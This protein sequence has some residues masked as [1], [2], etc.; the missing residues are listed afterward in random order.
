MQN[1]LAK[2]QGVGNLAW[3]G[4]QYGTVSAGSGGG[5]GGGVRD[6]Q[7][8]LDKGSGG[9]SVWGAARS[10]VGC[11]QLDGGA[12]PSSDPE[13]PRSGAAWLH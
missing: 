6:K 10:A 5:G 3:F 2:E 12:L 7:T 4:E 11:R 8:N 13:L 1:K 9:G